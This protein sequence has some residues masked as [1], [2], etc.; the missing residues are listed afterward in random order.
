MDGEEEFEISAET[1]IAKTVEEDLFQKFVS[2]VDELLGKLPED[3]LNLF[4][5]S[6]DFDTYKTIASNPNSANNDEKSDFFKLVNDKLAQLPEEAINE[7][8]ASE[9]WPLYE[10]VGELYN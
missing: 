10:E 7:F 2:I 1:N 6:T 4:L 9:N 8:I 3:K 5:E